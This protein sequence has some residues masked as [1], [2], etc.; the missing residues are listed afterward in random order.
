[1]NN[2]TIISGEQGSG[3]TTVA[4]T[5]CEGKKAVWFNGFERNMF[6][7]LETDTDIMVIDNLHTIKDLKYLKELINTKNITFRKAYSGVF[8]KI[9]RPQ[10]IAISQ[11]F[12]SNILAG[13]GLSKGINFVTVKKPF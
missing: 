4:H 2:V 3:K 7:N 9:K 1:M 8:N 5:L 11:L 12:N 6:K 13:V 10:V